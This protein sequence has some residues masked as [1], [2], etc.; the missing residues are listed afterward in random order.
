MRVKRGRDNKG[1]EQIF[2]IFMFTYIGVKMCLK[3]NIIALFIH[4]S[5]LNK[6]ITGEIVLTESK[7]YYPSAT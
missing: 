1:V 6:N 5:K 3:I 2:S 7:S 4:L